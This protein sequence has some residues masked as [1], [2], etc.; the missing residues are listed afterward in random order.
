MPLPRCN[1]FAGYD[2]A[3]K[4]SWVNGS[5]GMNVVAPAADGLRSA[6]GDLVRGT[7]AANARMKSLG[8]TWVGPASTAAQASLA[9]AAG[10]ASETERVTANGADR[11]LD[12]GHSYERMRNQI[13]FVD[14]A[15]YSWVQ[16]AGDNISE[17]WQSL[18][19]SGQDHV[20]IGE[21]NQANDA[22]ANRALQM[23]QVE[24]ETADNRFTTTA[25]SA[26]AAPPPAH[27]APPPGGA[28]AG[29]TSQPAAPPT[30]AQAGGA[31]EPGARPVPAPPTA[32]ATPAAQAPPGVL[33]PAPPPVTGG[34]AGAGPGGG[35]AAPSG[36]ASGQGRNGVDRSR[37]APEATRPAQAPSSGSPQGGQGPGRQVPNTPGTGAGGGFAG[38][39]AF[40][41]GAPGAGDPSARRAELGRSFGRDLASSRL[42]APG[43]SGYGGSRTGWGG[44][45]TSG[46]AGS[47]RLGWGGESG[48]GRSSAGG[49]GGEP[50]GRAPAAEQRGWARGG[51]AEG[52]GGRAAI[53]EPATGGRSGAGSGYAPMM[54]GAGAGGQNGQDHRNRYL[55]PTDEAFDVDLTF[56]PPVLG[57]VSED[58]RD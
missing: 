12:Y 26:P 5:P 27:D 41:T 39:G 54:G 55:I 50:G 40:G 57:P 31:G 56:T 21:M 25:A 46:G 32:S 47:G 19:G 10:D 35:A 8:I 11:L 1:N 14:P 42:A 18:W 23:H 3:T 9:R 24:T 28:Q 7:E 45:P 29:G 4:F 15:R 13:A 51:A 20:S 2:L 36:A 38:G 58:E 22:A 52:P 53:G 16:R 6:G 49:G 43:G 48:A 17:G 37:L 30:V 33:T 44:A 34:G